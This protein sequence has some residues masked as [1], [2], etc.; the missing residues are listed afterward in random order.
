[1]AMTLVKRVAQSPVVA[2]LRSFVFPD[3]ASRVV[4]PIASS[5]NGARPCRGPGGPDLHSLSGAGTGQEPLFL[6]Q[7]V[8]ELER[9]W[10][11]RRSCLVAD[12][13]QY[14]MMTHGAL[15]AHLAGELDR[16]CRMSATG[17]YQDIYSL[18]P[19]TFLKV[20]LDIY[21]DALTH[22]P[23]EWREDDDDGVVSAMALRM[24]EAAGMLAKFCWAR[25][26]AVL[27]VIW[28]ALAAAYVSTAGS[29]ERAAGDKTNEVVCALISRTL[30]LLLA[31]PFSL[32][33][34]EIGEA[35][36]LIADCLPSKALE[37]C[38][39]N[40]SVAFDLE[41]GIPLA[42]WKAEINPRISVV[43]LPVSHVVVN[44]LAKV[45]ASEQGLWPDLPRMLARR[46]M[47]FPSHRQNI[48]TDAFIGSHFICG[49]MSL[50]QVEKPS[51]HSRDGKPRRHAGRAG[52]LLDYSDTGCR[53]RLQ[54][55]NYLPLTPGV[56]VGIELPS[57]RGL[58]AGVIRW[59]KRSS[60]LHAEAGIRFVAREFEPV[61]LRLAHGRWVG[62]NLVE[63]GLLAVSEL[64]GLDK[65]RIE[66]ILPR[67]KVPAEM[68]ET[69]KAVNTG[70]DFHVQ[71]VLEVGHDFLR[72]SAC[73]QASRSR[74][75]MEF[76]PFSI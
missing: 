44:V 74:A 13:L 49:A 57:M 41:A 10:E 59:V 36:R 6:R 17:G 56:L 76:A 29:G 64:G 25:S 70:S 21:R 75:E 28:Q 34:V 33:P 12:D 5:G 67:D 63:Y 71:E 2:R 40:G 26:E 9:L 30:L 46:W 16:C 54:G 61:P 23:V 69:L 19:V 60:E 52:I 11:A 42:S 39:S 48:R 72:I 20:L 58:S 43:W 15:T 24:A 47:A 14:V 27:P 3:R 66:I 22:P 53:I 51:M 37:N 50:I 1:M 31:D 7:A 32:R 38:W 18:H 65:D 4:E 62:G 8:L 35:D 73:T 55:A 45:G 68:L